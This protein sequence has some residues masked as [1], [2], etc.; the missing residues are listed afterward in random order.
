MDQWVQAM[1][2]WPG[3]GPEPA[4]ETVAEPVESGLAVCVCGAK[5]ASRD[6]TFRQP[7][8]RRFLTRVAP[9]APLRQGH[10]LAGLDDGV[11]ISTVEANCEGLGR[12]GDPVRILGANQGHR[13]GR[14]G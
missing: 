8:A 9:G 13:R 4:L 6:R 7:T 2:L 14:M 1:P 12:G 10:A 11:A 3:D 5:A